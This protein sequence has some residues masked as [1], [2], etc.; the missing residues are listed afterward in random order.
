MG[1]QTIEGESPVCKIMKSL[2]AKSTA[3]HVKFCRN[4]RGPSRKAKYY[5]LTDS[6]PVP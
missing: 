2:L 1:K 5:Q 3:K 6:E 4:M